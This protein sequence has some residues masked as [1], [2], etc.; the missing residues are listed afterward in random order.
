MDDQ[1][2]LANFPYAVF[3]FHLYNHQ[4]LLFIRRKILIYVDSFDA[5]FHHEM[6]N[7][8]NFQKNSL[9]LSSFV[10]KGRA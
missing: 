4:N 10:F 9:S 2:Y 5:L 6:Y 7:L 3:Y 8:H 1:E